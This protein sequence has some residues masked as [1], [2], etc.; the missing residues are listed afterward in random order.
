MKK[1]AVFWVLTL[2][3][4]AFE[5]VDAKTFYN[6]MQEKDVVILDVRTP[7]EFVQG[8]IEGA[9]LIPV[10]VFQYLKLGGKGIKDKKVLVYCR[11]GNRSVTASRWLESWGVKG[12]YNLKG[13]IIEWQAARLPLVH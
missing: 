7:Q 5:N 6:L 4:F 1:I 3:L 13:G 11:S 9:N 2:S 12:V 10:Q 8:H